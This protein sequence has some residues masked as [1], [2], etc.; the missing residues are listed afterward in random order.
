MEA[1]TLRS[2]VGVNGFVWGATFTLIFAVLMVWSVI[3]K[4]IA[5][6]KSARLGSKGWFVALLII[7]TLG[8]LEILYIYVFSKKGNKVESQS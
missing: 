2:V 4:G 3:W 8:I 7:N 5:L 6:W 1:E